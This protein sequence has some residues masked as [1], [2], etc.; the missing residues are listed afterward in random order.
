MY[1]NKIY[2][3]LFRVF[4]REF[5]TISE[6]VAFDEK[7]FNSYSIKIQELHLRICSEIE[8]VLKIV[9]H[10]NFLN[11]EGV[12]S[13]WEEKKLKDLL[14]IKKSDEY[15]E[16]KDA[17]NRKK[18]EQ[19][20]RSLFGFPDFSFYLYIASN[21]IN[22]NKKSV[23][24][25]SILDVTSDK[26]VITPFAVKKGVN[27]PSWWTAYNRLKHDKVSNFSICTLNDLIHSFAALFILMVY[28]IK[29]T[30]EK[31]IFNQQ[32]KT[33]FSEV[34]IDCS[35][36]DFESIHFKST[37][38]IEENVYMSIGFQDTITDEE[39]NL[40]LRRFNKIEEK[41]LLYSGSPE[42]TNEKIASAK[43]AIFHVFVDYMPFT[44]ASNPKKLFRKKMQAAIFV[45]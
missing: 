15:L 38:T 34:S 21:T 9:V 39:Y 6:Y 27:V 16:I 11:Q 14:N 42:F 2:E 22:L 44:A 26:S 24:F 13:R 28:L 18:M 36:W 23:I 20:D 5:S 17:L 32:M 43:S 3:S 29:Y 40:F 41:S 8:N 30:N 31:P 35:Y 25:T 45:N 12:S 1:E 10:K 7:N 37:N 33:N 4:E 19:V